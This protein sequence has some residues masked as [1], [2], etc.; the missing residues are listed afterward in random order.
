MKTPFS[1]ITKPSK[2]KSWLA[3][4]LFFAC[5]TGMVLLVGW[6]SYGI[7]KSNTSSQAAPKKPTP[8]PASNAA[9]LARPI[10]SS[11]QDPTQLDQGALVYW[12]ICMAC[13]GDRGE[14]LTNE[15]R[16]VYGED[17]NCWASKCHTAN[18]PPQGFIIPRN[19]LPAA[20]AGSGSLANYNT[21]QE[22]YD[23]IVVTMPWWKPGSLTPDQAWAVTA[24]ILKMNG[25]LPQGTLLDATDASAVPVHHLVAA[26][27]ADQAGELV[28]AALLALVI[29]VMVLQR[30][31]KRKAAL[32]LSSGA[33]WVDAPAPAR[34][35]PNFL[36]HLHPPTI[37]AEQARWGYTLGTGGL[38]V[39]LFLELLVTGILEMFY[40]IPQPDRATIS[41]Q[42]IAHFVPY[43]GLI[44]N[45]HYWGAQAL[46]LVLFVHMLRITLTGAYKKPRRFNYLLGLALLLLTLALDFTG[47]ILRWDQGTSWAL[48]V[49][50]NLIKTIPI[51]GT[52]LYEFVIGGVQLGSAA[53]IRF[54]SWHTFGLTMA[55]IIAVIWH[56]FR[57][58]RDGGIAVPAPALRK[59]DER[60]SRYELVRREMLLMTAGAIV[61]VLLSIFW[62]APITPPLTS[63]TADLTNARAPWFFLWVQALLKLGDPFL[64][65][66]VVPL[67]I[68]AIL[69]LIPYI[70][71]KPA[72]S[73]LG[74]WFPKG[75]RFVQVLIA[76]LS[77]FLIALTIW[78]ILPGAG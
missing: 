52:Q 48:M 34:S 24:Y 66:I 64:L 78:A 74:R 3:G 19:Q 58:R 60:I 7:I 32:A 9:R 51:L 38:A 8:T 70:F 76:A 13:H 54:Y 43:G 35:R 25:T 28:L 71:P 4:G 40:Y 44:R 5:L 49:G 41:I 22:L 26:P 56:L 6:W 11:P 30:I 27:Q 53:L 72:D 2:N 37:P 15:W 63:A 21:A 77:L 1:T 39:F 73:E 16:A 55:M 23:Y 29:F 62:P 75:G 31:A 36:H 33:T 57:I 14:G 42:T 65:G 10:L 59:S 45:L 20:V 17:Q 47:Y 18:H 50:T 46:V 61:L 12:G 67:I 69:V 68:L